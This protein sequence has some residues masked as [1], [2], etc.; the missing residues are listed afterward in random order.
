MIGVDRQG[1]VGP[2]DIPV[3]I[4]CGGAGMRLREE[5]SVIPKPMVT[6]GGR[7][8]LWHIMKYFSSYGLRRFVLCLG[9]K[10]EAIKQYFLNYNVLANSFTL[11]LNDGSPTLVQHD[12]METWKITFVETGEHAMTGARIKRIQPYVGEGTFLLTYGDG[13]CD[14]D[15]SALLRFH[16]DQQRVVT[17]TGVHPP[18]RFGLLTLDGHQVVRFAE[19]THAPHDF[20][21]G[22]FFVCE[23]AVFSYLE[24]DDACVFEREPLERLAREGQLAAF[25]HETFWQCMDTVRDREV[26]EEAWTAGAPWKRW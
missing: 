13:L 1:S 21:N 18:S 22:G 8:I 16:T 3:V 20:I 6:I 2:S 4:L 26:L 17:V 15:V 10:G 14:V 5:T 11:D 9:Y 23:P 24:D 19:K 7:P 25:R 12:R